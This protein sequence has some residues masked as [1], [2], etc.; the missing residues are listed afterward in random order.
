MHHRILLLLV[1]LLSLLFAAHVARADVPEAAHSFPFCQMNPQGWCPS[2]NWDRCG[3]HSDT[4][5]CK[6]DPD[7][8]G[9]PYRGESVV[10][11]LSDGK[12]FA[13]NCPSVGCANRCIGLDSAQCR[14]YQA[15]P[16]SLCRW[17]GDHCV[18]RQ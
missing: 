14:Q 5:S 18:D 12:G 15:P 11:C 8:Q 17:L 13:T 16:Y 1:L 9:L 2:A 6:A 10:A 3:R 7:C 4:P